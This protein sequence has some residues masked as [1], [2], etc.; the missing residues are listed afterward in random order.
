MEF[1]KKEE[2]VDLDWSGLEQRQLAGYFEQG[3]EH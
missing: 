3:N 2:V 1:K